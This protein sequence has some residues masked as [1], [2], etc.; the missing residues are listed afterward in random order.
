MGGDSTLYT[1]AKHHLACLYSSVWRVKQ[2]LVSVHSA[3]GV[4]Q[5]ARAALTPRSRRCRGFSY[6]DRFVAGVFDSDPGLLNHVQIGPRHH[7][8]GVAAERKKKLKNYTIYYSTGLNTHVY[9]TPPRFSVS[10][11]FVFKSE[12]QEEK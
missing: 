7:Q 9:Q 6:V 3:G 5:G 4:F 11:V 10:S 1:Q 2:D 12:I 8:G